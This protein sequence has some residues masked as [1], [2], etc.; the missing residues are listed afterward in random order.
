ML[1]VVHLR[2]HVHEVVGSGVF[3]VWWVIEPLDFGIDLLEHVGE[4]VSFAESIV[5]DVETL[6]WDLAFLGVCEK[7]D[8]GEEE[9]ELEIS[10]LGHQEGIYISSNTK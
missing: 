7:G 5:W 6:L 9:E 3:L 2:M 4:S 8:E 10:L 1:I